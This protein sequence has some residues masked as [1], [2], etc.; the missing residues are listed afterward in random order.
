M[1]IIVEI[2]FRIAPICILG[3]L[4]YWIIKSDYLM[5]I[6]DIEDIEE[7]FDFYTFC[8]II[9]DLNLTKYNEIEARFYE[10]LNP[11]PTF[12]QVLKGMI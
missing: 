1:L 12:Y 7:I 4:I 3:Y 11:K 6:E 2:I 8:S 5:L 10:F 9:Y